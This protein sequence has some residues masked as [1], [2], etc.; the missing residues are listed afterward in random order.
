MS[1]TSM[2][3]WVFSIHLKPYSTVVFQMASGYAFYSLGPD[4]TNDLSRNV[5]LLVLGI[6]NN[7]LMLNSVAIV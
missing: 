6:L 1:Y 3:K 4:I 5:F 2:N 7:Y